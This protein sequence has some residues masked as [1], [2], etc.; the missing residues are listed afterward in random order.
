M[1]VYATRERINSLD[2]QSS[3]EGE[4]RSVD[5]QSS[6]EDDSSDQ[7]VY[8]VSTFWV[9]WQNPERVRRARSLDQNQN[10]TRQK[11]RYSEPQL[12]TVSQRQATASKRLSAPELLEEK[13]KSQAEK[14]KQV[15]TRFYQVLVTFSF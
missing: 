1:D 13:T 12:R 2:R 4:G 8:N 7:G 3:L 11:P 5:R 10:E 6:M 15:T 9:Q 14:V